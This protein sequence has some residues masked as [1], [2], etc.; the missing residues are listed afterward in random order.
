MPAQ[1]VNR[2]SR[3]SRS[4]RPCK[5]QLYAELETI[6]QEGVASKYKV[7]HKTVNAWRRHYGEVRKARPLQRPP[8]Q[9]LVDLLKCLRS[10][11]VCKLYGVWPSTLWGWKKFY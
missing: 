10:G 4:N 9:H 2:P 1:Y 7:K 8:K 3:A 6:G 5:E 11:Y